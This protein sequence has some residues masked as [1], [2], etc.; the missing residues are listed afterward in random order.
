[1]KIGE[2]NKYSERSY[3]RKILENLG[4]ITERNVQN[5]NS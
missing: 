3:L 4:V 1:M 5:T 2:E